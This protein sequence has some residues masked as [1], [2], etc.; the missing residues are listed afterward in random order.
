MSEPKP[1]FSHPLHGADLRTLARVLYRFGPPDSA[2]SKARV[3]AAFAS[4]LLRLPPGLVE[5]LSVAATRRSQEPPVEPVFIIGHWRSGTTHLFNL[6]GQSPDFGYISPVTA[7]LPWDFLILGRL[8]RPF[9]EKAIPKDRKIDNIPVNPDSPQED[10]IA[11]AGMTRHSY[12]H[13]L[14]FPRHFRE[15]MN[16]NLFFEG[17]GERDIGEWN[18]AFLYFTNKAART[19]SGRKMLIK[20]PAYTARVRHLLK[21]YPRARFIHI[22][23]HPHEV[24]RSTKSFYRKLLPWL[25]LQNYSL[26][27]IEPA[28]F[29]VY[30][31]M[32][33]AVDTD[34]RDLPED[35]F[36]EVRF[37]DLEKDPLSQLR[38]IYGQFDLP[39]LQDAE[40][41]F[42]KH[43]HATLDYRKNQH[44]EDPGQNAAFRDYAAFALERWNY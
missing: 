30:D 27:E 18:S 17:V 26:P 4:A 44:P 34:S 5:K 37:A 38:R 43:I 9:L 7:G 28:V 25:A 23:R 11:L 24:L 36:I 10:E 29:E 21:L 6:L 35:R 41:R 13:A 40:P 2:R 19:L 3:G 14:F 12:Y 33:R 8:F 31:R 39:G 20:N 15:I 1:P 16:R 32:M 22:H 42:R